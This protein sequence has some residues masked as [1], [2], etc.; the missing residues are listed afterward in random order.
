VQ[1]KGS[2]DTDY[3]ILADFFKIGIIGEFISQA[4]FEN[5]VKGVFERINKYAVIGA[6]DSVLEKLEI[7][8]NR[9]RLNCETL[10]T[11]GK[12]LEN[13]TR[14][15]INV[16]LLRWPIRAERRAENKNEKPNLLINGI[17]SV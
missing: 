13:E 17:K 1:I 7:F 14:E 16:E 15:K 3:P 10:K 8:T 4:H 6:F 5:E 2:Y 11:K 9:I 12:K